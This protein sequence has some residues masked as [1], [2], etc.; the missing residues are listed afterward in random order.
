MMPRL[1]PVHEAVCAA[2][3]EMSVWFGQRIAFKSGPGFVR[4][5]QAGDGKA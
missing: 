4:L 3:K 2:P 5:R 1:H